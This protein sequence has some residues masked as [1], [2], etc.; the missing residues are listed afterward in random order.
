[1][2]GR[3]VIYLF[4]NNFL[5][6]NDCDWLKNDQGKILMTTAVSIVTSGETIYRLFTVLYEEVGANLHFS[7]MHT[8][9]KMVVPRADVD[10]RILH[11]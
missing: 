4:M 8:E 5:K 3:G 7:S 1:M 9:V 6:H 10:M 2:A 11:E